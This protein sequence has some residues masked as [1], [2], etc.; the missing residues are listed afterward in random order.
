MIQSVPDLFAKPPKN[1]PQELQETLQKEYAELNQK[2][3]ELKKSGSTENLGILEAGLEKLSGQLMDLLTPW[4]KVGICRHS[5]RPH[6][7]DVIEHIFTDFLELHG[8]RRFADDTCVILGIGKLGSTSVVIIA[9]DKGKTTKEKCEKNFGMPKPEG[10][11]KAIRGAKLAHQ[12]NLPLITLIDTPGAYPGIA[13]EERGQAQ[14]IAESIETFF[15]VR[16][17]IIAAVIGEGGSGGAL[18]L[19]VADKILMQQFSL[20]S[21]ISPE[22]CASIL[23]SDAQKAPDAAQKLKMTAQDCLKFGVIDAIIAEPLG[24]AHSN[25]LA[26]MDQLKIGLQTALS[27]VLE[28]PQNALVNNR[29]LKFRQMG[30]QTMRT[31]E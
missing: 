25:P 6:A 7:S 23:W 30:S 4:E 28:T 15:T 11:R 13:A 14:A 18:A 16:S 22:S 10:Y 5:N 29:I 24:G 8:D 26:A 12:F 27:E 9:Q 17:P 21:V 19:G 31:L 1:S 20:Y 2:I 3:L